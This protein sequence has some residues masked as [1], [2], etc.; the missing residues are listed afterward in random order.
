MGNKAL[1]NDNETF[2]IVT[3]VVL[4]EERKAVP[5]WLGKLKKEKDRQWKE[6]NQMAFSDPYHETLD[7]EEM[8]NETD[9]ENSEHAK[10]L[11]AAGFDFALAE[12]AGFLSIE[13]LKQRQAEKDRKAQIQLDCARRIC[14]PEDTIKRQNDYKQGTIS[15]ARI[16][17]KKRNQTK[18]ILGLIEEVSKSEAD[19]QMIAIKKAKAL[20][21]QIANEER[22]K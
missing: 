19:Y 11:A 9:Q 7:A 14:N 20:K 1:C 3:K 8:Q 2:A 6:R 22:K 15:K 17:Q 10:N 21:A 4:E 12:K 18:K 13:T 16:W 5:E